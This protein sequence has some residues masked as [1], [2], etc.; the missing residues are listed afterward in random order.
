MAKLKSSRVYG[1]LTVDDVLLVST[2]ATITGNL[3]VLGTTTTVNSTTVQIEGPI[4]QQGAGA[5][6]ASLT[7]DDGKDR[8]LDLSYYAGGAQKEAFMGWNTA[9][10]E[11]RFGDNVTIAGDVV[12]FNTYGNVRALHYIGQG[13]QLANITGSNVT[14]WVAQ[15]NYANYAGQVTQSAQSNI[16]SVGNL[17]GLQI[18]NATTTGNVVI[19]TNGNIT[20]TG[21]IIANGPN[22]NLTI[23]TSAANNSVANIYG[24]LNVTG[25]ITGTIDATIGAKGNSWDIQYKDSTGNLAGSDAFKF[26]ASSDNTVTIGTNFTFVGDTGV[27]NIGRTVNMVGSGL[28]NIADTS[29][30]GIQVFSSDY[31]QLNYDNSAYVYVESTGAFMEA[32]SFYANL[33]SS[34]GQFA[35]SNAF[36]AADGNLTVDQDGNVNAAG[37]GSFSDV[38]I[39]NAS[40]S[41]VLYANGT[42][43]Y[44]D[45]TF[46]YDYGVTNTLT[47]GNLATENANLSGN[48]T[49]SGH[50][51]GNLLTTNVDGNIIDSN[52]SFSTGTLTVTNANITANLKTANLQVT[53]FASNGIPI[54]DSVGNLSTS[55]GLTY[56]ANTLNANNITTGGTANVG[57]LIVT[58]LT[59]NEIPFANSTSGIQGDA[60]FTYT[61][62]TSTL[63]A[64]NITANSNITTT[65]GTVSGA[66]LKATTLTGTEVVFAGTGGILQGDTSFTFASDT[67]TANSINAA[68]SLKSANIY[69]TDLALHSV[70]I[71][72]AGGQLLDDTAGGFAYYTG[73]ATLTSNN[74]TISNLANVQGNLTVSGNANVQTTLIAG[75]V[76][77]DHLLYA[78]GT[79]WDFAKANG[80]STYIQYKGASGD[81]AGSAN[82][83]Y[84]DT[85]QTFTVG[86]AG[87]ANVTTLNTT[88]VFTSNANIT[89]NVNANSIFAD[90]HDLTL[91]AAN[92]N[93]NASGNIVANGQYITNVKD[94]HSAQDAATKA[95]VDSI[96]QGLHVHTPATITT[97]DTLANISGGTVTYNDNGANG[98]GDYITLSV[99]LDLIDGK[100][101]SYLQSSVSPNPVRILVKDQA[102]TK[103]NGVYTINTAGDTLTRA[104]DFDTPAKVHGGDFLFVEYGTKYGATGWVQTQDTDVIGDGPSAHAILFD[105]FSGAGTFTADTAHGMQLDGTVFR[106]KID[107]TTLDGNGNVTF[108]TLSYDSNGNIHVDDH[109]VFVA[110]N[111][112]DATGNTLTLTGNIYANNANFSGVVFSNGNVTLGTGSYL[113]GNVNGTISGNIKVKG[114]N[115]AIQLTANY[116]SGTGNGDLTTDANLTYI[117]GVLSVDVGNGGIVETDE[118]VGNIS[119]SSA[120]QSNIT[121]VGTLDFLNVSNAGT[122]NGT[123]VANYIKTDN[124]QHANGTAWDFATANGASG[125]IQFSNGTDLA[126]NASFTFDNSTGNL[127]VPGN[128]ITGGGSGGNIT[129]ANEIHANFFYGDGSNISNVSAEFV[130]AANLTGDT[131]S[132]NVIYSSLTSVGT[133]ANLTVTD[134]ITST[135]GDITATGGNVNVSAGSVNVTIGDVNVTSGNVTANNLS[136][137][138]LT[139]TGIVYAN[140]KKLVTDATNFSYT[141]GSGTLSVSNANVTTTLTA[142]NI[143]DAGLKTNQI[144]YTTAGNAISGSDSFTYN[145]TTLAVQNANLTGN[146]VAANL[147]SNNV[148]ATQVVFAG[149]GGKLTSDTGLTYNSS[150]TTLTANNITA[151]S[152]A[153]LGAVGN[154]TITGGTDGQYLVANGSSGG[155][156]WASVDAAMISNGTSNVNIVTADGNIDMN[157]N[158]NLIV[159]VTGTGANVTGTV[160]VTGNIIGNNITSNHAIVANGTTDATD[161]VTGTIKTA[162]GISAQGNIYTGDAV[163]FAHGSGNTDSAA[164]IK[165]NSSA[166]SI[167]FIFN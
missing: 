36:S 116:D 102:D 117:G 11:F 80:L 110:P 4:V 154:V 22:S 95:Y 120:I 155:L 159:E 134:F 43:V 151:T 158:G 94:P 20:A 150:T 121:Q 141:S 78:N 31:A 40:N 131:L 157:V 24:N 29:N 140:G 41:Y 165:Y 146:V 126:S 57:N 139:S 9:N 72:G 119:A 38:Y 105:Q 144:A 47:A 92:I 129:G 61:A 115:G 70:V 123:V 108:G 16:T 161:A 162:G 100:H 2:D 109:A 21:S 44:G 137:N 83:T 62:G 3:T 73:N 112:G 74:I 124:L 56:S 133:L 76:Q 101:L 127:A 13:D 130:A 18:G 51:A 135:S 167:D 99:A 163:G 153:N 14:G 50:T 10:S 106:T 118:F 79:A 166:N 86:G 17:T 156:K 67:L 160:D 138:S 49:L 164:Y 37:Y 87:I 103:Q 30:H 63:N 113:N 53:S 68:V 52:V 19:D 122:G 27:A 65:T 114:P 145:G 7:S 93:L 104:S 142:G 6:G 96:A 42:Q 45:G 28:A 69:D 33:Y 48:V 143:V 46:T 54:A 82:F 149:T 75:N 132:S 107:G 90:S 8:G 25:K 152:S 15:A 39:T 71:A 77:T 111:I 98:I 84:D 26:D 1:N 147:T 91:H 58:N 35:V 128:I 89:G 97:T 81:L 34:N 55:T 136:S 32:G 60:G 148:T 5:N 125:E 12:T 66:N 85:T 23:G 59:N 64:P 88:D